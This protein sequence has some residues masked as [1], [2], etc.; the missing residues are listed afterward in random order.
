M[1]RVAAWRIASRV[2]RPSLVLTGAADT[3]AS[4]ICTNQ[5][6]QNP[7]LDHAPRQPRIRL[8]PTSDEARHRHLRTYGLSGTAK[9]CR[10]RPYGLSGGDRPGLS[11]GDPA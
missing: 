10:G 9:I 8:P 6:V 1:S 7:T 2:E 5:L 4:V 3:F 11:T